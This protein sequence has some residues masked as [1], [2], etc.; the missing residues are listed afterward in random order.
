MKL[1]A[2]LGAAAAGIIAIV[3]ASPGTYLPWV[4]HPA[5]E[6]ECRTAKADSVSTVTCSLQG[7]DMDGTLVITLHPTNLNLSDLHAVANRFD[8]L[9]IETRQDSIG[10]WFLALR[11][12]PSDS[13]QIRH[14]HWIA[15]QEVNLTTGVSSHSPKVAH[16]RF[17]PK[18]GPSIDCSDRSKSLKLAVIGFMGIV[19]A[20]GSAFVGPSSGG[21]DKPVP[22]PLDL[23]GGV[24]NQILDAVVDGMVLPSPRD[25][26]DMRTVFKAAVL[27]LKSVKALKGREKL[28]FYRGLAKF[29]QN[30]A[31]VRQELGHWISSAA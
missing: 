21:A 15:G 27:D 26:E 25:T 29:R 31:W 23:D 1:L 10:R 4:F 6:L 11:A 2:R 20:F 18:D 12:P 13:A 8:T 17:R 3:V 16:C 19:L 5:R 7:G 28:L 9:T 22:K 14:F 24:L 30:L